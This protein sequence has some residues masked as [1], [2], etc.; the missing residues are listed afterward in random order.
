MYSAVM[1]WIFIVVVAIVLV[2]V[3]LRA[4]KKTGSSASGYRPGQRWAYKTR[5]SEEK[6]TL[7]ILKVESTAIHIAVEDVKIK[8]PIVKGGINERLP[9][10]PISKDALDKS[11]TKL[12][13]E[14]VPIPDFAE[15]YEEWKTAHGGV[16]SLSVAEVIGFVEQVTNG[17]SN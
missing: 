6:S 2:S 4:R 13:A 3:I 14:S 1:K 8:S 7:I 11:V 10:T 17:Q 16:F 9:H 15:G 12:V 5:P